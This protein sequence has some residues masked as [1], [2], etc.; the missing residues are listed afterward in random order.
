VGS[1]AEAPRPRARDADL[2]IEPLLEET[3]VYDLV[4]H[5][6]FCLGPRTA[7]VWRHCDGKTTVKEIGKRLAKELRE[8]VGEDVIWVA[9][10]RLARAQLLREALPAASGRPSA[11]RREWMRRAALLGG[12]SILSLTVPVAALAASCLPKHAACNPSG[13]NKCCPGC[14]CNPSRMCVGSC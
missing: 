4:R 1:G 12:F 14:F 6:A 2:V 11:S 10:R 8:P 9:L 13:P 5:K 3:L 7:W